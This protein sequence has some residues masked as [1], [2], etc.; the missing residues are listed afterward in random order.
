MNSSRGREKQRNEQ[1]SLR[2]WQPEKEST[3][4]WREGREWEGKAKEW[5]RK[6]QSMATGK[7]KVSGG[8]EE[9]GQ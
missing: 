5:T 7:G 3:V 9:Y 4:V 2:A 8:K 1:G 6:V